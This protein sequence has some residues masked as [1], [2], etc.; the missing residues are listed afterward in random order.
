MTDRRPPGRVGRGGQ[1]R[2]RIGN[3]ADEVF[4]RSLGS[5]AL[6]AVVY[7]TLASALYFSLGAVAGEAL[8]LTPAVLAIAAAFFVLCVMTYVEGASLHQERAGATVFARY[9]FNEFWS[10]VAGWAILLDF[11]ILIALAA[12]AAANYMA[13]FWGELSGGTVEAVAAVAII[14]FVA[15][16]NARGLTGARLRRLTVLM[17]ADIALMA[18]VILTG[19]VMVFD[20]GAL[21]DPISLG[22]S[23]AWSDVVFATAIAAA[24]AATGLDAS[25]GLAGEVAVGRRGLRRLVAARA[26]TV[27]LVYVGISL[28]ALTALP[29][30]EGQTALGGRHQDAPLLGVV[31]AYDPGGALSDVLRYAVGAMGA[32]VLIAGAN[33][34]MLGLSRLAYSLATNRQIPSALGRLHPGRATPVVVIGI[35]AVLA[36]ALVVPADLDFLIGIYAFGAMLAF[37]IAH[38]SVCVLRYR[39]PERDRPYAMPLSLRIG[40]G[41]LPLPAVLGALLAFAGWVSV[42]VLHGGARLV[43]SLWMAGGIVLYVAYRVS[44]DKPLGRR[45]TIPAQALSGEPREAEYSSILVPLLG[46]DFDDD[47]VQTAGRLAG[48]ER[49]DEGE[50]GAVIEALWVFAVPMSLPLDAALP[51][52][53]VQAARR[54]LLRAK[55]VGE[56]YEGVEVATATVRARRP[57]Q[58][59]VEQARR[60]GVELIVMGAEEPSRLRGG[61]F[62][63]GLGGLDNYVGDVTRYV[64]EKAHCRVILTAPPQREDA[65]AAPAPDSPSPPD[66]VAP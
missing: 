26:G 66:P 32:L 16:V 48:E 1:S 38:L 65:P 24:A 7:T 27:L 22:A 61:T 33:S 19:L 50:M 14:A 41:R 57:G 13:A 12:L 52:A 21:T 62:L 51:D 2:A 3:R 10:F 28:V 11:V 60:R 53:R 45:V 39:E 42:I 36:V 5:P 58:A 6:F 17:V 31:G 20:A 4:R 8:G 18:V 23:P 40:R 47:L 25:S 54:A 37:T 59:I 64:V 34:A 9:A 55:S 43:G 35:A 44:Q 30:V 15:T 29:V 63:G 49:E 46:T 56:E